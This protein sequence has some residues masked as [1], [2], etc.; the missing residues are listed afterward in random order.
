MSNKI[1]YPCQSYVQKY[2]FSWYEVLSRKL[3]FMFQ[4]KNQKH[5]LDTFCNC[6]PHKNYL[7]FIHKGE[8]SFDFW[9][10]HTIFNTASYA[11]P[12]M[13]LCRRM[14]GSNLGQL[15]LWHWLPDALTMHSVRSHPH[16]RLDLIDCFIGLF[17]HY[18]LLPLLT[19]TMG[20]SSS[21]WSWQAKMFLN[22]CF[23]RSKLDY[24]HPR[25]CHMH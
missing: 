8:F 4:A 16:T 13:S 17:L 11:A 1:Q 23:P 18:V 5:S 22:L 19:L 3:F 21:L 14:L 20:G 15:R 24:D 12:Q 7:L 10:L 6:K 25:R 2:R 9:F